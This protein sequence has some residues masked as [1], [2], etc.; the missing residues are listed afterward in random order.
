MKHILC[1]LILVLGFATAHAQEE[2][3]LTVPQDAD[4]TVDAA[5]AWA[6]SL[7]FRGTG[8]GLKIIVGRYHFVGHG[9]LNCTNVTGHKASYKVR[10]TMRTAIL[11]PGVSIGKFEM[12]GR[13][14]EISLLN[15]SPRALL[16]DY[17]IAQ[18]NGAI[19]RGVGAITA[20]KVGTP[21]VAVK[22]S[23]QFLK[24][25]GINLA[26]NKMNIALE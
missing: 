26:L 15:S 21:Q 13:S 6:C 5:P 9:R 18:G 4:M 7:S 25:F 8:S 16:G 3:V 17:L 11:S 1:T 2:E 14:A 24:G 10:I 22:V 20:V 19:V 23:L 12:Q